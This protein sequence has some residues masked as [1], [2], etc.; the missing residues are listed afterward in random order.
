MCRLWCGSRGPQGQAGG[1]AGCR[2]GGA[3]AGGGPALETKEAVRTRRGETAGRRAGRAQLGLGG[4][5]AGL[6]VGEIGLLSGSRSSRGEP[7]AVFYLR[8][9]RSS[10]S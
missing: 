1:P 5:G 7:Q 8:R 9:M 3:Q 4:W 10:V 6:G 2:G